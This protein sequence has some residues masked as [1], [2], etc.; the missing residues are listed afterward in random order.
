MAR[1]L[2]KMESKILD[3]IQRFSAVLRCSITDTW[4]SLV[5]QLVKNPP[6]MMGLIP[7]PLEEAW[8][9]T[10]EFWPGESHGQRRLVGCS[11]RGCKESNTPER[12][13]THNTQSWFPA[14][15]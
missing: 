14:S 4:A 10:P 8:Q 13:M 9:L 6:A 11:S 3:L 15:D 2:K 7:D 1:D 5:G 12:L